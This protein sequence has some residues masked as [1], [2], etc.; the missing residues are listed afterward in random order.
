MTHID[1]QS[2]TSPAKKLPVCKHPTHRYTVGCE[3]TEWVNGAYVTREATVEEWSDA[4]LHVQDGWDI[5]SPVV[6]GMRKT[7]IT[8]AIARCAMGSISAYTSETCPV[9]SRVYSGAD[10]TRHLRTHAYK[11][12][13]DAH[14]TTLLTKA[15]TDAYVADCTTRK[16][17][18]YTSESE[19]LMD[20]GE[21]TD[22]HVREEGKHLTVDVIVA[23]V[24]K[25]ECMYGKVDENILVTTRKIEEGKSY[26][27]V[28]GTQWNEVWEPS[29]THARWDHL[30]DSHLQEQT[31][32]DN[33]GHKGGNPLFAYLWRQAHTRE[34][35]CTRLAQWIRNTHLSAVLRTKRQGV[36]KSRRN[37]TVAQAVGFTTTPVGK[38]D[39]V[40]G[41]D[42][43][44]LIRDTPITI[45][46]I[47][48]SGERT[49]DTVV[50]KG[51]CTRI[52]EWSSLYLT[53]AQ[54]SYLNLL[55]SERVGR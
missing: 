54:L 34:Q 33:S 23:P 50:A 42:I 10:I 16:G 49:G 4:I 47:V 5:D 18:A 26:K 3:V 2:L 36:L 55:I 24:G 17:L 32:A 11:Q 15:H 14:M 53:K 27:C 13:Q 38:W 40:S 12:R 43:C 37:L 30:R 44:G 1:T 29:Y 19:G 20:T 31:S 51:T 28:H 8:P 48:R 25:C 35:T 46:Y 41:S 7:H 21:L 45:P 39:G 6:V 52:A 9:C 22:A